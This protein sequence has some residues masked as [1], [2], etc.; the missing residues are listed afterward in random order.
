LEYGTD[1][2]SIQ[3]SAIMEFKKFVIID[4]LLATGGT[5]KCIIDLLKMKKKEILVLSVII[6][7][8][9]LEGTKIIRYSSLFR[10]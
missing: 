1:T 10:N 2:L 4:D 7:L 8:T 9:Q 6:E 3:E 5:A